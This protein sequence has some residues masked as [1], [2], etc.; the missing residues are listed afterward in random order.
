[1]LMEFK[2]R[3]FDIVITMLTISKYR[4]NVITCW[5]V[6]KPFL[7]NTSNNSMNARALIAVGS[8]V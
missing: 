4:T 6:I 8:E 2:F 3:V 5:W 1:M 7:Q